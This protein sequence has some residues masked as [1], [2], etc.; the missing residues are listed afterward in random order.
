MHALVRFSVGLL[1][2]AAAISPALAQVP[3]PGLPD[4]ALQNRIP[5][6][7]PPPPEPPIINGPLSQSPPPGVYLPPRINSFSDRAAACAHEGSSHG[8][9]GRKL[10]VY[11]RSCV[12]AN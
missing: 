11:T 6:P 9:R 2:V 3:V 1:L 4:P 10:D 12:N 5:A 8:L 7:L